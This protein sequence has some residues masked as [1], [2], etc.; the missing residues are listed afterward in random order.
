MCLIGGTSGLLFGDRLIPQL[1][2]RFGD[3]LTDIFLGIVGLVL[4]AVAYDMATVFAR[5]G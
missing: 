2:V 3:P 4:T 5:S 1:E